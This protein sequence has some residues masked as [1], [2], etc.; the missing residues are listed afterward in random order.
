MIAAPIAIVNMPFEF[1]VERSL[2]EYVIDMLAEHLEA[3]PI[4]GFENYRHYLLA[5]LER[6]RK[7]L[8]GERYTQVS[9]QMN[10]AIQ[11]QQND[12]D[13]SAHE[14]WIVQLLRQYYDPMYEYQLQKK[15]E[16]IVFSGDYQQV[17]QWTADY[18]GVA[19]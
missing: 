19:A 3:D 17:L 16:R 10:F 12:D 1:R 18:G 6:I 8:G 15:K 2:Q 5:S 14:S 7:R 11:Q 4:N 13:V 9:K